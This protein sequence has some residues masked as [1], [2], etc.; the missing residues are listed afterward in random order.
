MAVN[1]MNGRC[2][3]GGPDIVTF[4]LWTILWR[5]R[6]NFG[7]YGWK[8]FEYSKLNDVLLWEHGK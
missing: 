2:G 6:Q 7:M 1:S 5:K 3:W 4:M 8:V